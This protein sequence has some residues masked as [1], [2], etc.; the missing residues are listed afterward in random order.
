MINVGDP[1]QSE[2]WEQGQIL[3]LFSQ[4][5][6]KPHVV[7]KM[8][9]IRA[10]IGKSCH[11]FPISLKR[12]ILKSATNVF[13]FV[14]TGLIAWPTA[15]DTHLGSVK[16][17]TVACWNATSKKAHFIQ[18]SVL[19]HFGQRDVGHH[20]VLWEGAGTHEVKHLLPLA[21]EAWGLI[22]KQPLALGY[23]AGWKHREKIISFY[24]E[25]MK[26]NC[27][28]FQWRQKLQLIITELWFGCPG[29]GHL[30]LSL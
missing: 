8:F 4:F 19:V 12:K 18:R 17:S 7:T 28:V 26:L 21:S 24:V 29:E 14:Q 9:C 1:F 11:N 27:C 5:L 6:S 25:I 22:R 10:L 23:S 16:S 3:H 20:S 13:T 15:C 2:I 30:R